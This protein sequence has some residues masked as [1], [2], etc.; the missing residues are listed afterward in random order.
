MALLEFRR[1]WELP[2]NVHLWEGFWQVHG[3]WLPL[4]QSS[5]LS[6]EQA[7]ALVKNRLG[8]SPS[9][10][11][12][13]AWCRDWNNHNVW[14][15]GIGTFA[16]FSLFRSALPQGDHWLEHL[17]QVDDRNAIEIAQ[18]ND[19]TFAPFLLPSISAQYDSADVAQE[20]HR[21]QVEINELTS[22]RTTSWHGNETAMRMLWHELTNPP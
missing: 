14:E 8:L 12:D 13:T 7:L 19:E 5:T 2:S 9:Q 17:A 18:C 1:F 3:E 11:I 16:A 21:L 22:G 6:W 15:M 10:V 4:Y 20:R